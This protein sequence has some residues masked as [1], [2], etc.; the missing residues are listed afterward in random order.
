MFAE[1]PSHSANYCALHSA[2]VTPAGEYAV[3]DCHEDFGPEC[4]RCCVIAPAIESWLRRA[5]DEAART[6]DPYYWL[7]LPEILAIQRER[8]RERLERR[9]T[10]H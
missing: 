10:G 6:G 7:N 9:S 2:R 5:F 4:R 8:M 1:T 3:V